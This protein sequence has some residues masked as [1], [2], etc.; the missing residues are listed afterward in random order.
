[1]NTARRCAWGLAFAG[2]LPGLVL[3]LYLAYGFAILPVVF[4]LGLVAA[5]SELGIR[6]S[7]G[8]FAAVV[9]GFGVGLGIGHEANDWWAY[10]AMSISILLALLAT[11]KAGMVMRIRL[12]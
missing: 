12:F 9:L 8:L 6:I 5:R 10:L 4:F 3:G 2:G 11:F 7:Q 1:M